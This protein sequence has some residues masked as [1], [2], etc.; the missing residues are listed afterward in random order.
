[1][2]LRPSTVFLKLPRWD[3]HFSLGSKSNHVGLGFESGVSPMKHPASLGNFRG[4]GEVQERRDY[5]PTHDF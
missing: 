3:H 4:I 2:I 1:M 5:L